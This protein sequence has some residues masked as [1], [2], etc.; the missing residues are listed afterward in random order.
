LSAIVCGVN[1]VRQTEM[2]TVELLV[3][4]PQSFEVD[5]A[6][7]KL[8]RYKSVGINQILVAAIQASRSKIHK[9]INYIWSVGL[10]E[11]WKES[12]IVPIYKIGVNN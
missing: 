3:P 4:E 10:P 2:H 9:F 5:I 7:E 8:K 11:Q 12:I 1:D 6:I